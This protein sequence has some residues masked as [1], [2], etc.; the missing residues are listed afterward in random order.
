[1]LD[2]IVT[3]YRE[4]WETCKPLFDVL[5][6][7]KGV[8]PS[9]FHVIF[10]H[11]GGTAFPDDYFHSYP[12]EVEQLVIP[13]GGVSAARNAG[14]L[15][16]RAEWVNFCDCDD[17]YSNIYAL[18]DVMSALGNADGLDFLR[19]DLIVEDFTGGQNFLTV[20]PEKQ[21][22]VFIHGKYYRRKWLLETGVRFDTEFS[23]QEDSLFNAQL[24]AI[25]DFHKIGYIKTTFPP[26]VWVRRGGSVT[27]SQANADKATWGHF[28]RNVRVC[29]FFRE[30]LPDTRVSCMVVRS[31]YDAFF[32]L[33]SKKDIS[34][35]MRSR[36]KTALKDFLADFGQY[37]ERPDCETL[38]QIEEISAAELM[39]DP[40]DSSFGTVTKWKELFER[41]VV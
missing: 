9:A 7:Q 36:L 28:R 18:R 11:D 6:L 17:T 22:Y 35:E 8:S 14:L 21:T 33:N 32:M 5:A 15:H 23:F 16:A 29:E 26:Y 2:I 38:K 39:Q 20:T 40:V 27:N 12:Y 37:W 4:T 30:R 1:M 19:T 34:D 41:K 3:H 13:H 24:L 25:T 31:V 10:V